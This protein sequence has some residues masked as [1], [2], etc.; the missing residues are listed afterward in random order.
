MAMYR[1]MFKGGDDR[2]RF[3]YDCEADDPDDAFE[4]ASTDYPNREF[5]SIVP[6]MERVCRGGNCD[7]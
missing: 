1:V 3:A 7:E 4:M 6:H 2:S 5:E